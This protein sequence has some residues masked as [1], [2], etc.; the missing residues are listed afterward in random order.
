MDAPS[1]S[2]LWERAAQTLDQADIKSLISWESQ[3]VKIAKIFH[4]VKPRG[5]WEAVEER[6]AIP[7]NNPREPAKGI[8]GQEKRIHC[9]QFLSDAAHGP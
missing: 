1:G 4:K 6:P 8:G 3:G 7:S 9:R 2:K 5:Y